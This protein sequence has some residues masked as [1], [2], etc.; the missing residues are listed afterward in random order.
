MFDF[1]PLFYHWTQLTMNLVWNVQT[2]Q[3]GRNSF[4]QY[5]THDQIKT[6]INVWKAHEYLEIAR[7]FS[8]PGND[9]NY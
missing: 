8:A 5:D 3:F 2:F 1:L 4:T 9:Q 7:T 6:K